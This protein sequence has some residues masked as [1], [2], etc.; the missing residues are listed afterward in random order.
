M[1]YLTLCTLKVLL[2]IVP[3]FAA[4]FHRTSI[5]CPAVTPVI[6][7]MQVTGTDEAAVPA[8]YLLLKL[9]PLFH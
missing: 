7:A 8:S 6:Y 5:A 1:C 3:V 2:F 9:E 4:T